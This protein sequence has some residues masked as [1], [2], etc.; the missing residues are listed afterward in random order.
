M[1]NQLLLVLA[2][3]AMLSVAVWFAVEV[4]DIV[5]LG[6]QPRPWWWVF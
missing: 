4:F 3:A 5:H 6:R 2:F 1:K